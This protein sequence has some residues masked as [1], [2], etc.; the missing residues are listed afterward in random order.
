V[1]LSTYHGCSPGNKIPP[2]RYVPLQSRLQT[3]GHLP[4]VSGPT[5]PWVPRQIP[6]Q[7]SMRPNL[8]PRSW[9]PVHLWNDKNIDHITSLLKHGDRDPHN[10][11]GYLLRD[12]LAMMRL[13]LGLPEHPFENL[14]KQFSH[15]TMSV[16]L[17]P[18]WEFCNEHN[19]L[20][21]DN[22]PQLHL[23]RQHDQFLVQAF[24]DN[25]YK[26]KDL[27]LLN[28]CR[29][30]INARTLAD[31][32]TGDGLHIQTPRT[33]R[34]EYQQQRLTEQKGRKGGRPDKHCWSLWNSAVKKCFLMPH[35]THNRIL[36]PLGDWIRLPDDWKWFYAI[37]TDTLYEKELNNNWRLW[38]RN[39]GRRPT[40]M[41]GFRQSMQSRPACPEHSQPTTVTAG[42]VKRI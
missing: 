29:L 41:Q 5:R 21:K 25:G 4:P 7:N 32:T 6:S 17:Q 20:V 26:K 36:K 40:R 39:Q 1:D 38:N 27:R 34:Q 15:C 28:I 22:Q 12:E 30:W 11:T 14:Y 37:T 2:H 33:I 18:T 31:I 42:T 16:Y 8:S 35:D 13:E 23:R 19:F 10:V 3:I 24:A 9:N